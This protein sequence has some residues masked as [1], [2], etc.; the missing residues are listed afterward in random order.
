MDADYPSF[1]NPLCNELKEFCK[2]IQETYKELKEDLTPYR[3]DRYYSPYLG[4]GPLH[5]KGKS[6]PLLL[7]LRVPNSYIQS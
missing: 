2:R 6:H 5:L 3:D 4:G 1:E 7:H